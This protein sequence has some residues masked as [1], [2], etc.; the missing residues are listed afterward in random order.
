MNNSHPAC[1]R[2]SSMRPTRD[3]RLQRCCV[4]K[5]VLDKIWFHEY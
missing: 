2:A 3:T 1:W 5:A 4:E